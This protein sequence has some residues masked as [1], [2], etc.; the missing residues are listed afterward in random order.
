MHE[1][2]L[3]LAEADCLDQGL[4]GGQPREGQSGGLLEREVGGL[5]RH[6]ADGGG[7][8]LGEGAPGQ[9]VLADVRDDLVALLVLHGVHPGAYD[10]AGDV[11]ARDDGE[12]GFQQPVEVTELG[13][14]VHGVDRRCLDLDQDCVR[15]DLGLGQVPVLQDLGSA[16]CA[17]ADCLHVTF[18]KR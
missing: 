18:L 11:P 3:A 12:D 5:A 14:P 1:H 15:A 13:L 6:R 4:I 9:E 7:H 16:V 2:G 17:V 10:H 8:V